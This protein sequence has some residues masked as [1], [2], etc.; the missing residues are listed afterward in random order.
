MGQ[1]WRLEVKSEEAEVVRSYLTDPTPKAAAVLLM[2]RILQYHSKRPT[3]HSQGLKRELMVNADTYF[4]QLKTQ[5]EGMVKLLH[6]LQYQAR[7]MWETLEDHRNDPNALLLVNPPRYTGGYDHMFKGIDDALD[8]DAP[9]VRQFVE[10][11]YAKLMALLGDSKALTL[12]YYATQGED[13]S[14]LWG[15]PWQAVFAD[16][17]RNKRV[18]AINWVIA[19]EQPL[20]KMI[21]RPSEWDIKAAFPLF[22][23]EVTENSKLWAIKVRREVGEYYKDLLIHKLPG[24]LAERYVAVLLDGSLFAIVGLNLR[25]WRG[26]GKKG[27]QRRNAAS[28]TYAF[29]VQHERYKRLHKL[30]LQSVVSRWFWEAVLGDEV[31]FDMLGP[32]AFV[33]STVITP[34]PEN[35]TVRG[36]ME[37]LDRERQPDGSYKLHYRAAVVDRTAKETLGLWQKKYGALMT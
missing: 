6:G 36:I 11:D 21:T 18:A 16:K 37:M 22:T 17:P 30:T 13:P 1:D 5:V 24:A 3:I 34:Y 27:P 2:L 28:L 10:D 14:P 23:G 19:N 15:A 20:E 29:T 7:D 33:Y 32:P 4:Q 8:W 12:M 35:K 31:G 9:P 26:A 25:D